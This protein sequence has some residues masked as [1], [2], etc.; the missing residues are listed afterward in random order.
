METNQLNSDRFFKNMMN[1]SGFEEPSDNFDAVILEKI[2]SEARF[3]KI[4]SEPILTPGF[5][6]VSIIIA[7]V[8]ITLIIIVGLLQ[9]STSSSGTNP[10]INQITDNTVSLISTIG[11]T[12]TGFFS[13]PILIIIVLGLIFFWGMDNFLRKF[14]H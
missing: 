10:I 1:Y 2:R 8:M 7:S 3:R 4:I 13:S 5:K 9:P 6:A 14:S 12:I 11:K